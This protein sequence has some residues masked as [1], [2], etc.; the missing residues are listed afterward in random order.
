MEYIKIG[1]IFKHKG[2][3][4]QCVE[5]P[6]FSCKH[7]DFY[8][9][10]HDL[11]N[12]IRQNCLY[13]ER[14][15]KKNVIFKKLEK[16]GEPYSCSYYGDNRL[17]MMQEYNLYNLDDVTNKDKIPILIT[18]YKHKR[19]AIEVKQNKED[20]EE[21]KIQHYN[22]LFDRKSP[23]SNLKPFDL[24]AAK[25]GDPVCTRDERKARI[26]CFDRKDNTPIVA[27]IE[28]VNGAEI[29]QCYF[30]NGKC[31]HYA[32]SD[33]DLMMLPE[34]KEGWV[35]V[36]K[37]EFDDFPAVLGAGYVYNTK[38]E[39]INNADPNITIAT[40]KIEWDA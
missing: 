31:C 12:I 11:C 38:E 13:C 29:L 14:S 7:C 27:L 24:K 18:D 4:Y 8:D 10:K 9:N 33:Y 40:V 19:I 22:C 26:I 30:N 32:T 34:K 6:T 23:T 21:K 3:W 2:E 15:D 16:V 36:Y 35:N 25:A 1:E 39:A 5:N 28:C 17:I 37:S 20:M